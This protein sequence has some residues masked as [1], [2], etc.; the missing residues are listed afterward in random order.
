MKP[1][2]CASVGQVAS[3]CPRCKPCASLS[4]SPAA[5]QDIVANKRLRLKGIV[6]IYP[7]NSVGDDI[8]LYS[9]EGRAEVRWSC[10]GAGARWAAAGAGRTRP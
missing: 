3:V 7:A 10:A 8:E 1:W 4:P 5:R 6:G 9:D 2:W